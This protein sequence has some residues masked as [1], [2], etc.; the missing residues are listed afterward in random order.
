MLE[1]FWNES[2]TLIF[3]ERFYFAILTIATSKHSSVTVFIMDCNL[4][5]VSVNMTKKLSI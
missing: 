4:D 2:I 5:D 1:L 3:L